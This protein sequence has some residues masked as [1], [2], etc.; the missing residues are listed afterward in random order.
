MTHLAGSHP[1]VSLFSGWRPR[2]PAFLMSRMTPETPQSLPS[3]SAVLQEPGAHAT[4]P[5]SSTLLRPSVH[6]HTNDP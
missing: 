3:R 1:A 4:A 5:P 2:A 6:G